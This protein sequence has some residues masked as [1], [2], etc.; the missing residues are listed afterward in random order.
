MPSNAVLEAKKAKVDQLTEL[1]KNSVSG[2]L[3]DYKGITVEEDTK[4]RKE[5]REGGVHY[6]VEKNTL[7]LR[8]FQNC[9][10]EGLEESLNG[11]TA[12]A[13]S[14]DDQT[15]PARILGK[16]AEQAGDD[17]FNLKAGY[18]EGTV[19]DQAGV[20][21]LSKIPSKDTLLAQLVGSLQ[22]PLQK[23]AATVKAVADKKAEEEA[24]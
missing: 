10:I 9:G 4:L 8:A 12:I 22:G 18:V 17:K 1:I 3:V 5:L 6:F 21:A 7:L 24:A 13:L 2:V 14:N 11:T 16:F 15:A 20:V 23:L 19:Y